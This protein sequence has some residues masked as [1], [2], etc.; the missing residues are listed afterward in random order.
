MK[1]TEIEPMAVAEPGGRRYIVLRLATD[2]GPVGFSEAPLSGS[3][4][5]A[6]ASFAAELTS[7]RSQD[8]A[9]TLR[10]D[11]E[12][13]RSGASPAARAAVNIAL[14]DILGKSTQAPLYE[15]L[16]GPTRNKARA[17]AVLDGQSTSA[18]VDA[19]L[20]AKQVGHRAFSIPLHLPSGRERGRIFYMGIRKMMDALREAAGEE[21]DFVL[22][23]AGRTTP[24]EA[25]SI[26]DRMEDFHLLWLDEPFGD[27]NAAAEASLSRRSSTPV[28]LGRT[29]TDNSRF[30]DLLREGAVDVLRPDLAQNGVTRI[31]KAAALAETY[32]IDVAPF[33]R[34]GPIGTATGIHI[35]ASLANSFIQET[36]F[37][38]NEADRRMRR[39]LVGGWDETPTDGFFDLLNGSGLGI[40]VDE[41]ALAAYT[42]HS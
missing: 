41:Q 7:I 3:P 35:A 1:I 10:I 17:M 21:C 28:G 29:Y 30:Q 39:D 5:A 18:L 14:L 25:L 26:A 15:V 34:G 33:H 19:V 13:L 22:D 16:G 4:G 32:Y 37:S 36:P 31:K 2:E 27:L 6:V 12:L 40:E 9:L 38:L 24:G 23:C 11:R 42:I 8:P 20:R